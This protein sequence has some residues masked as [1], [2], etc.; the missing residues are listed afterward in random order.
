MSEIHATKAF[1]AIR[2]LQGDALITSLQY[3]HGVL[4]TIMGRQFLILNSSTIE[5]RELTG[6]VVP[7]EYS[8]QVYE[9]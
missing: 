1:L 4:L 8:E 7:Q 2:T 3:P 9:K 5:R 6:F